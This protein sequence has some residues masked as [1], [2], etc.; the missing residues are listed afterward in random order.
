MLAQEGFVPDQLGVRVRADPVF[1]TGTA[2]VRRIEEEPK[3]IDNL[4]KRILDVL[5]LEEMRWAVSYLAQRIDALGS[6]QS[7]RESSPEAK[8]RRRRPKKDGLRA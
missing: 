7:R 4:L 2:Y 6:K 1:A 3:S 5:S 8:I